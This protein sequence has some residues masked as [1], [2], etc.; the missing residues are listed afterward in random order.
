MHGI[1]VDTDWYSP[2]SVTEEASR[3]ALRDIGMDPDRPYFV[4]AGEFSRRKRPT[5]ILIALSQMRDHEPA[6][7]FLG[8]GPRRVEMGRLAADLGIA[9]RV[10]VSES[11]VPDIRPYVANAMALILA[12]DREGLPRTIM[13]ALSME[14]PVITSAARGCGE[15]VG[16]DR[17]QVVPIGA[18][19]DMAAAMDRLAQRPEERLAMGRRGRQLMVERY[20]L[21]Q[22]I[23][24]HERLYAELLA[25]GRVQSVSSR[26]GH[27]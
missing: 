6:L 20:G 2:A 11:F 12:S 23:A 18:P 13:E 24:E 25:V 16:D 26:T 4:M 8:D 7:L 1:G 21:D 14:V 27:D 5:D 9:D 3:I 15:L 22:L 19:M 10:V 17:G